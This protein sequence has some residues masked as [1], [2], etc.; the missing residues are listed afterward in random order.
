VDGIYRLLLSDYPYPVNIGNPSEITI[1][2]FA[3]EII[4]L[5]GAKTKIIY[6]PLPKDDPKQRQPDITRAREILNWEPLVGRAEGLKL[7]LDYFKT[8]LNK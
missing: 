7:T 2:Q 1:N 5:T 3:E 8:V 4:A 6:K